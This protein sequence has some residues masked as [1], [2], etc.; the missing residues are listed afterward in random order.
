M[1]QIKSK[2]EEAQKLLPVNKSIS[3]PEAESRA[4]A[5]LL[6]MAHITDIRH[7]L[8]GM[9]IKALSIQSAVYADVISKGEFKTVTENKIAAEASTAYIDAREE[10]E[11]LENDTSYLKTYYDIFNNAHIFYRTMAKGEGL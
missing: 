10:L 9:K 1:K 6:I 3:M 7:E 8:N 11:N 5:F 2:I 4:G